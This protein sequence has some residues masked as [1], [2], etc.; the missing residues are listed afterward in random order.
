VDVRDC[1][2]SHGNIELSYWVHLRPE[3]LLDIIAKLVENGTNKKT[4]V[5]VARLHDVFPR[6]EKCQKD[7]GDMQLLINVRHLPYLTP[8]LPVESATALS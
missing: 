7:G 6:F 2:G 5:E 8:D 4:S 3:L 1:G